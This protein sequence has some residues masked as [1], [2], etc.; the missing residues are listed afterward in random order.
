MEEFSELCRYSLDIKHA[1]RIQSIHGLCRLQD[2]T[3]K[4]C[5]VVTNLL[6][7]A[8]HD[9]PE[10]WRAFHRPVDFALSIC[11]RT[12]TQRLQ[13]VL[14][15]WAEEYFNE[16]R[17]PKLE[18]FFVECVF[19]WCV[20]VEY[21]LQRQT[22]KEDDNSP[23]PDECSAILESIMPSVSDYVEYVISH[24]HGL[25]ELLQAD[26]DYT[27]NIMEAGCVL[28]H[29]FDFCDSLDLSD[30]FERRRL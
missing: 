20:A 4:D 29:V 23:S 24:V 22:K 10:T 2:P 12:W 3:N 13:S 5:P 1:L 6:C 28:E 25:L 19:F 15:Q 26:L 17:L 11:R 27:E 9:I 16:R 30:E 21:L 7:L 18:K 8:R 14:K